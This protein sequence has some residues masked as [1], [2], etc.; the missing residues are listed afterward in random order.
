MTSP[1]ANIRPHQPLIDSLRGWAALSVLIYHTFGLGYFAAFPGATWLAVLQ[2]HRAAVLLFFT[3]SGYVIG[4]TNTEAW[5]GASVRRYGWRRFW[6]IEPIYVIALVLGAIASQPFSLRELWGNSLFLQSLDGDSPGRI[7]PLNGNNPLWSLH[8]EI[9]Y[10]AMFVF[11]WRW[12]ATIPLFLG[13]GVLV[14]FGGAAFP[15]LPAFWT[16]QGTGLVF[17]LAGLLISRCPAATGPALGG[18]IWA[19]ICWLHGAQHAATLALILRG[20]HLIAPEHNWLPC[21]DFILLPGCVTLVALSG[22]RRIPWLRTWQF[23]SVGACVVGCLIVVLAGKP[24]DEPRWAAA[25]GFTLAGLLLAWRKPTA[26]LSL[27]AQ[28]G[29]F[30]YGLYA[31]HMPVLILVSALCAAS[32]LGAVAVGGAAAAWILALLLAYWLELRWQPWIRS[33][34]DRLPKAKTA[35]AATSA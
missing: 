10:Y 15:V 28:I 24:L 11:W 25:L 4:S 21:G 22:Q 18:R 31:V 33:A 13:A 16:S 23:I 19:N 7:L 32:S 27:A 6:R 5:S 35:A 17:W 34:L 12:P 14:S 20:L 9:I 3:I 1:A 29:T 26:G 2:A 8:Y 30:S